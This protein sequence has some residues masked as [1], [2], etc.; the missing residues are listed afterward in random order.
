MKPDNLTIKA[1]EAV[2]RAGEIAENKGNQAIDLP[3]LVAAL[4]SEDGIPLEILSKIGADAK[5]ITA[6][7]E[8][9]IDK[10]PVVEGSGDRYA[11]AELRAALAAAAKL[12]QERGDEY[13]SAEHLLS[14]AVREASG[15]LKAEFEHAGVDTES[16]EKA[17][18][19][20]TGGRKVTGESPEDTFQALA[21]YGADLTAMAREGKIDPVIGRDDEIRR[22]VQVLLRRTKNNP[23]LIGEP[24][25][26]K[27]AI[28]EGLAQRIVDGDVPEGLEDKTLIALDMGALVA[29]AKY[30]GQF[31]ERLKAVLSEVAGAGG[32]IVLFIDEIHTVVGAGGADGAVDASNMLKP[33]LARG[34]LRCIGAT[35][36]DEFRANIEKDAAFERRFQQIYVGEPSVE[37]TVSILRGLAEKYEAHH[38]VRIRDEALTAAARLSDRYITGRFL[39]DKAVDLVDEAAAKIKMEIDSMPAEVDEARRRVMQLEMERESVAKEPGGKGVGEIDKK[40]ADLKEHLSGITAAWE[41]EKERAAQTKNI[42]REIDAARTRA[43]KAQ[44]E[45]DLSAAS[46]ILYGKLPELEK[47]LEDMA[48]KNTP[49]LKEEVGAADIA[50]VVSKWTGVPVSKLMEGETEKLL[51]MEQNLSRRVIGQEEAVR[52]V[53]NTVRRSRAGLADPA[54]P[55]GSLVFLGPTGVGK[56]ELARALAEFMFD[57][58]NNL[59]RIDMSEYMEKHSVSRLIGAPPGYVGYDEGG[60]LTE[61]VRR[62][63]YSVILLDEIEKAHTDIFNILLQILEDGR[64]TDGRG[65]TVNFRNC[66]IIMTSNLGSRLIQ[67]NAGDGEKMRELVSAALK[68]AFRPEFLNRLDETII[69][70]PLSPEEIKRIVDIRIEDLRARLAEKDLRLE[71]TDKA[72]AKLA[73]QGYDPEFGARPLKRV[74]RREIEDPLSKLLLE[75][76]FGAGRTVKIGAGAKGFNFR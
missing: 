29:G 6:A 35:T 68:D 24:G 19:E 16:V 34:E 14:G 47:T 44:R 18:R 43:E 32:E 57:D 66:V 60:Q 40:I 15:G 22:V 27:T 13:I 41:R 54:R 67:E 52:A 3:H 20:L 30:R 61:A 33:A 56:T 8:R 45:G 31:E 2:S 48:D 26:G 75:G 62:R 7:A 10:L 38:G 63:P 28:V 70:K 51:G 76:K 50:A 11:S 21:K 53:S 74:I 55:I 39:P 37:D 59:V 73:E 23:V 65:R 5:E 17:T 71:I 49:S 1:R 25:V 4:L 72:K 12:A 42:K 58:E 9:E 64:L 69:F 36:L 46:E